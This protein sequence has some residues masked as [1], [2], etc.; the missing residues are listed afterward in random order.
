MAVASRAW[1]P[2]PRS[3]ASC[4]VGVQRVVLM[5]CGA[6]V[7]AG[8]RSFKLVKN[9]A[10]SLGKRLQGALQAGIQ[11]GITGQAETN[12]TRPAIH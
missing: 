8:A 3:T 2:L 11:E 6:P 12:I 10:T 7:G 9:F 4:V 5:V 1:R